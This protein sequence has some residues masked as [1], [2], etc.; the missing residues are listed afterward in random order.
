[1]ANVKLSIPLADFT[2][3][4]LANVLHAM[5]VI[6]SVIMID[7]NVKGIPLLKTRIVQREGIINV[8]S[9]LLGPILIRMEYV[10]M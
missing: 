2:I 8:L 10:R 7:S 5:M 9:V 3:L 6:N 1:V 4:I